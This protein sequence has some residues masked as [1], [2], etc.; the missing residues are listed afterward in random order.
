[1]AKPTTD[2]WD[3]TPYHFGVRIKHLATWFRMSPRLVRKIMRKC[4]YEPVPIRGREASPR[5]RNV[6]YDQLRDVVRE[7]YR[8][9]GRHVL[10]VRP[11]DE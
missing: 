5:Y 6:T 7:C 9:K 8:L 10:V 11:W 3:L 1:M 4:G 2:P